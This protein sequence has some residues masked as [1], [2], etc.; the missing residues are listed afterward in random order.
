M[1]LSAGTRLGSYEIVAPLGAGGMG[2]V[3][4]ARDT[5]LKREVALKVLPAAFS[6]DSDRLARFQREAEL[7]A[8]LN[9]PHIAAIYGLE[10]TSATTA[11]VLE[12]V[13]GETLADRLSRGRIPV[14]EALL[15]ARQIAEAL[16]S[17]HEK[18]IVHRDLKPANIKITPDDRVK[19]LDFGL[20]RLQ[21]K[22]EPASQPNVTHS[23]TLS[24]M[25]TQAGVILGTAAY[26][27]PEQAKGM[28]ADHRS[29]VFSFGAVLYEMLSGR[30]AFQAD[31]AAE[32]MAA[33][34]MR[35]PDFALLPARLNPR[36]TEL[37]RRCLEKNPR[38]RW[39]AAGDLRAEIE[40]VIT[41]PLAT[42]TVATT[43]AP[44]WKRA[45]PFAATALIAAGI[46]GAIAWQTRPAAQPTQ[47]TVA[48]S[49]PFLDDG[50]P[51][52]R[53]AVSRDGSRI[54][55]PGEG[56]L[57]VRDI[58]NPVA[59]PIPG[60]E[61]NVVEPVFSP[62][63]ASIAFVSVTGRALKTVGINGGTAIT[64]AS[65]DVPFSLD[66]SRAGILL[67]QTGVIKLASPTGGSIETIIKLGAGERAHAPQLLPDGKTVLF[68]LIKGI[69]PDAWDKAE[70]VVQSA[71]PGSRRSLGLPGTDARYLPS[72]HL[73][74]TRGGVLFAAAFDPARLQVGAPVAV[75]QGIR[76]AANSAAQLGVSETGSLAYLPGPASLSASSSLQLAQL[77]VA[78][79]S[80]SLE[81]LKL[82]DGPY[83]S[84]RI[85]P[86]GTRL[87]YGLDNGSNTHIWI[88]ELKGDISPRQLTFRGNN[89][90]PVWSP[91]SRSIAFQS[92][93][94]GDLGIFVQSA[95]ASGPTAE[96]VTKPSPGTAH[97]PESWSR[98]GDLLFSAL[99]PSSATLWTLSMRDKRTTRFGDVR[100]SAP[101]NAEFSPDGTW[102][103]YNLRG[104]L[105]VTMVYVAAFPPSGLQY[106]VTA[107]E[108][109]GHHPVWA[110]DG[111]R[112]FYVPAAANVAVRD[113]VRQ[114]DAL[115]GFREPKIWPGKLPNV[116]PFGAPR[117]FDIFPDGKRFIFTRPASPVNSASLATEASQIQVVVNWIEELR[118]R[119][120]P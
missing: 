33:V 48:F 20:A 72:G 78:H 36:L 118:R 66:W 10:R 65:V 31:T 94:N 44:H 29:D 95:D 55:Y 7:L 77:A 69:A 90:Y 39:H 11:L 119:L 92:D 56:R 41:A 67:T 71:D 13:D 21:D 37:L 47:Q 81:T 14:D 99:D 114:K 70:I 50:A 46:V 112:L 58:G 2:E 8:T 12:L 96:S 102:V 5:Q 32:T 85:S 68:T 113:V 45:I 88:Y 104:E 110:P 15:V 86:D 105:A 30:Q 4:R 108:E 79:E 63:G 43:P 83:Q 23:P 91:D 27:S 101:F 24:L 18:G 26:M 100:S 82:P 53:I 60:T 98:N 35:E 16:E 52:R 3:Y 54:V 28:V 59:R 49:V 61:N 93:R 64:V 117:N 97:V 74:F 22:D 87:A 75:L 34:L 17:A 80:G 109:V 57:W 120:R 9:H 103:A 107:Q 1:S 89:R 115:P 6:S 19:V 51:F 106:P 76:R 42:T 38:R 40:T 111:D 84:P 25:A 73:V 116:N 62:D